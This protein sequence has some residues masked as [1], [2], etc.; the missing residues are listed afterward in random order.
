[1]QALWYE[2]YD[3]HVGHIILAR[4]SRPTTVREGKS[5]VDE[6]GWEATHACSVGQ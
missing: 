4:T 3:L 6:A 1:M 5:V 2:H